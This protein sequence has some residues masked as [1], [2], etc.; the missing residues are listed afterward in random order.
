MGM[1]DTIAWADQLPSSP[2]MDELGL[3]RRDWELQTKCL[4][5]ALQ[6]YSVQT[7]R[8]YI[9]KYRTSEW[10]EGDPNAKS[11]MDTIGHLKREEP[12]WEF[13]PKTVT[14]EMYDSRQTDEWDCWIE[15]QAIFKDGIVD[16]V[17]L[18]AFKKES[19]TL[20]K[21]QE[22]KWVEELAYENRRWINRFF[23]YTLPYRN[24]AKIAR[25]L[26]YRLGDSIIRLGNKL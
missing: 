16:S 14:I 5:R 7:G 6:L 19:N 22:K 23:F 15:F 12:Y 9:R 17:K 2:E 25:R 10:V 11:M 24:F 3:N 20:R 18:V 4:D 13:V 1:F 21:E 26:T 8:L